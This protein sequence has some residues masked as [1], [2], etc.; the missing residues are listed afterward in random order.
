MTV[1]SRGL[2]GHALRGCTITTLN[3]IPIKNVTIAERCS[4]RARQSR[5]A[6]AI[7]PSTKLPVTC[8]VNVLAST[9]PAASPYPPTKASPK[10]S[11]VSVKRMFVGTI[12]P[13]RL[14]SSHRQIRVAIRQEPH[15]RHCATFR[16]TEASVRK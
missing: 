7:A 1:E 10:E 15:L 3:E 13:W 4:S 16:D 6:T 14:L 8:P 5:A 9:K 2:D 12:S 11:Q